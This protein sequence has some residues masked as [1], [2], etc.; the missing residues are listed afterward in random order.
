MK[1]H[2]SRV[3]EINPVTLE[4]VWEYSALK[5][6][7]ATDNNPNIFF[8]PLQGNVQRLPNGNTLICEAAY[9]RVF[10]VTPDLDTVWEY[11]DP[12]WRDLDNYNVVFRAYRV[13]YDWVPQAKHSKERAVVP[14]RLE[15]FRL[16]P[17]ENGGTAVPVLIEK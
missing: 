2:Y 1:R 11:V 14:P 10:E 13:P 17:G 9:G 3:L 12:K 16:T 7:I 5:A 4:V 8:S 15:F 6:K